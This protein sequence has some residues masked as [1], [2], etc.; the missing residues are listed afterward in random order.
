MTTNTHRAIHKTKEMI[1]M[2]ILF[3]LQDVLCLSI[4]RVLLLRRSGSSG[5]GGGWGLNVY[6]PGPIA[7]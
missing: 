3:H 6:I 5:S 2:T 1:I 7:S 4:W